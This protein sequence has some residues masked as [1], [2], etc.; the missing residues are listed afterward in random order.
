MGFRA[1]WA[2]KSS[3]PTSWVGPNDGC[4]IPGG[5]NTFSLKNGKSTMFG[6]WPRKC[7]GPMH[8][9]KPQPMGT[10]A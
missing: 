7:V 4:P 8:N 6:A 9:P 10:Q 3:D 2:P 5:S 1:F